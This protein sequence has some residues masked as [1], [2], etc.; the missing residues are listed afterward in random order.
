MLY[1][2]NFILC[3]NIIFLGLRMAIV[4]VMVTRRIIVVVIVI[5]IVIVIVMYV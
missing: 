1:N 3:L 5:V 4:T 2:N